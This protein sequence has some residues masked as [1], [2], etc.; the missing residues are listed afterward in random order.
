MRRAAAASFAAAV[1]LTTSGC[2]GRQGTRVQGATRAPS[3]AQSRAPE[4]FHAVRSLA[5]HAV[6]V[7]LRIPAIGVDARVTKLGR[8]PD[9]TVDVPHSWGLVGWYDGGPRPGE[10]GPAVLLGHV[11]SRAGPAVFA[12]LAQLKAGD[13]VDVLGADGRSE[14][15]RVERVHRY[16]KSRFPTDEVYLP[17]VRPELRLVTCGGAFDRVTGHYVDNVVAYAVLQP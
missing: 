11:D 16:P 6:P 15:F 10:P 13:A 1:L 14:R 3:A 4:S 8:L 17:T 5:Q 9:G 7:R 2:A 12:R